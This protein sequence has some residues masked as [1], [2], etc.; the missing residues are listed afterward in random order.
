MEEQ[1]SLVVID[2]FQIMRT[3]REKLIQQ[4]TEGFYGFVAENACSKC[5]NVQDVN[6]FKSRAN[7]VLLSLISYIEKNL[8][9]IIINS[10]S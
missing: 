4:R 1:Y 2:M 5:E 9:L 6:L 8:I 7:A 10:K 3:M